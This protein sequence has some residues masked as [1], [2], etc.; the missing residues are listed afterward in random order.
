MTEILIKGCFCFSHR[1]PLPVIIR[2]H[3]VDSSVWQCAS[4]YVWFKVL[5]KKE[6][7]NGQKRGIKRDFPLRGEQCVGSGS[8]KCT[9]VLESWKEHRSHKLSVRNLHSF[10]PHIVLVCCQL[11]RA[12]YL[13]ASRVTFFYLHC[14]CPLGKNWF[15]SQS[16]CGQ[17]AVQPQKP[18]LAHPKWALPVSSNFSSLFLS[19]LPPLLPGLQSQYLLMETDLVLLYY[20]QKRKKCTVF[21]GNTLQ[22]P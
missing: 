5:L 2:R 3:E 4:I 7:K 9:R 13:Q 22:D 6:K 20:R 10:I 1:V 21:M 14:Q 18:P 15:T 11:Y 19:H 12:S 16:G 8:I 17:S